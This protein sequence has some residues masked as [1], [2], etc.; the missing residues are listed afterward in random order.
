LDSA[1]RVTGEIWLT[2]GQ[3]YKFVLKTSTGTTIGTYDN[4]S[5]VQNS[6]AAD[7]AA[8]Q[9]ADTTFALKGANTDITSLNAP[10]LGAA[11]A[12]T[13]TANDNSTKVATTAFVTTASGSDIFSFPNPTLTGALTLPVSTT[14]VTL[15]FRSTTAGSGV[16]TTVT[17]TPA[18][19]VVP[20]GATLGT[21]NAI[22]STI[23][24]VLI[25]NAGTLERAVINLSGGNNLSENGLIN[26]IAISTGSDSADVF[27]STTAR[28]NVAYR[29]VRSIT[30]TQATA[31]SWVTA[32]TVVQGAGGNALTSMSSIG[33]GQTWQDMLNPSVQR[34]VGTTYYNT[35]GRP[36]Q[37]NI[38][39]FNVGA[40]SDAT[41]TVSGVA[42][43]YTQGDSTNGAA[44]A[45]LT[46]I[47]PAGASYV[48]TGSRT[49]SSGSGI[50]AELR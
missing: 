2:S 47:I 36:I 20:N 37:V 29:V 46:A 26:T 11:T 5:S 8:L 1:G 24:E 35:T 48:L 19:L 44:S 30:S 33:Y 7:I 28:S 40:N 50:W 27:Y 39:P 16:A 3:S 9:A 6:V 43:A 21:T 23:V 14:P 25:N 49:I 34:A 45:T 18:A 4:I 15:A 17:G 41:L 10:A 42:V 31:G 32:P 22:Q 13:A 38:F 12:T